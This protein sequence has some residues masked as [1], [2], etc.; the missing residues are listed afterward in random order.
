M[1]EVSEGNLS[2]R[3]VGAL[4]ALIVIAAF[5]CRLAL[6]LQS[7]GLLRGVDPDAYLAIAG[8]LSLGN[9]YAAVA[10]VPTAYR[11]PMYPLFLAAVEVFS[12]HR[13]WVAVIAQCLISALTVAGVFG[14]AKELGGALA[15]VLAA[16][17]TAIDPF[18]IH[19]AGDAMTETLFTFFI[20]SGVYFL[21][22]TTRESGLFRVILAALC[23]ALAGMTRPIGWAL[24]PLVVLVA[25]C[26]KGTASRRL[27]HALFAVAVCVA[28][29]A[30]WI[31][32][33]W[34]RFGAFIP[35]TTHGGYTLYLGNNPYLRDAV[36]WRSGA[37]LSGEPSFDAFEQ[38]V[39]R[40]RIGRNEL[41]FDRFMRRE[42]ARYIREHPGEAAKLAL[43]KLGFFWRPAPS[44]QS[45]RGPVPSVVRWTLGAFSVLLYVAAL[46]G[47]V[48][49]RRQMGKLA[50]LAWPILAC[51][52]AHAVLWSQLR[53]RLP[54]H[55]LL[56]ALAGVGVG[57]ILV[58][59]GRKK[60]D[61][62]CAA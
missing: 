30:P 32:R 41:A 35:T 23:V 15:G 42:G 59:F 28:V 25:L 36:R 22:L 31:A 26:Q 45:S 33:N 10:G 52:L 16:L 38:H 58:R 51:T 21:L 7:G 54:L 53:F 56:A 1:P 6:A 43:A 11:P 14:V 46:M 19:A 47:V 20:V 9:G 44:A 48:A 49:L 2:I 39:A 8:N 57:A 12:N 29:S 5:V 50:I 13:V 3:R 55:P 24:A 40:A 61:E 60:G 4:V 62:A 17:V 18:L 34:V 27:A 37:W